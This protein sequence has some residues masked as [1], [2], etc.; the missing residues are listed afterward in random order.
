MA[1]DVL[2]TK[3]LWFLKSIFWATSQNWVA[4][5]WIKNPSKWKKNRK[6]KNPKIANNPENRKC[7]IL[8]WLPKPK[9]TPS[10]RSCKSSSEKNEICVYEWNALKKLFLSWNKYLD[11]FLV[12]SIFHYSLRKHIPHSI[13]RWKTRNNCHFWVHNKSIH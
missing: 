4:S 6:Q 2:C 3:K 5:F 13:C 8:C 11:V 7:S 1:I 9:Q 12:Y 10:W